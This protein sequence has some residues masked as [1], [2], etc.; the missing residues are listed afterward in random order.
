MKKKNLEEKQFKVKGKKCKE[1][2]VTT[3]KYVDYKGL[4]IEGDL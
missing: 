4:F 2:Y 1:V 3:K